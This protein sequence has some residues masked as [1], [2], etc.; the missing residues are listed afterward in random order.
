M[1]KEGSSQNRYSHKAFAFKRV[2]IMQ[3][4]QFRPL[5]KDISITQFNILLEDGILDS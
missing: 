2:T 5:K 1:A 4:S 3:I